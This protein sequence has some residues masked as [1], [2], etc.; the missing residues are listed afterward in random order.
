MRQEKIKI[1]CVSYLNSKPFIYGLEQNAIQNEI[2]LQLDIPSM[3]AEKLT[4][5]IVDIGLVPIAVLP[6]LE[7]YHVISDY[8]IGADGEVGSVLLLSHVPLEEI[9]TIL[10][11]YQSRTSV[12]LVKVL[13]E[14]FW[15]VKPLWIDGSEEYEN[16]IAGTTAG[17]VIG[18]RTFALKNKFK[19]VYDLAGEWKKFTNLPFVFACWVSTKELDRNFVKRFNDALRFGLLSIETVADEYK[20]E[21]GA[22]F[23]V[24][25]YL[26]N[27]IS[28]AFDDAKKFSLELFLRYSNELME[29]DLLKIV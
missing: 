7:E 28:Y 17:V 4:E 1:S 2:D 26:E 12:M 25:D 18:D 9:K 27:K 23:D 11:D 8:C 6:E 5:N 22:L 19:Y 21:K 13:A 14:K 20:K 3:C 10:L 15:K 29:S 24:K 16:T